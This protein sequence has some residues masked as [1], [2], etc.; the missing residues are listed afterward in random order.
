MNLDV[1]EKRIPSSI[2][3]SAIPAI[4]AM[5]IM[6]MVSIVDGFFIGNYLGKSSLA[7]VNLEFEV[8]FFYVTIAIF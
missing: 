8:T 5:I 6:S 7:A 2:L 1:I 3:K 4:A